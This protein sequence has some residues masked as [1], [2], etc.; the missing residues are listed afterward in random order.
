MLTWKSCSGV[1]Y[2]SQNVIVW[3][4]PYLPKEDEQKIITVSEKNPTISQDEHFNDPFYP[5]KVKL[6][7]KYLCWRKSNCMLLGF[8]RNSQT[9]FKALFTVLTEQFAKHIWL[10][11]NTEE[12]IIFH[13]LIFKPFNTI[14]FRL[15][16]SVHFNKRY[17]SNPKSY[18]PLWL[19]DCTLNIFP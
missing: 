16:Q 3:I 12:Q 15:S 14:A 19:A 9:F 2:S 8:F 5:A 6:D 1:G 4:R 11:C 10:F 18:H 13:C 7:K 17:V